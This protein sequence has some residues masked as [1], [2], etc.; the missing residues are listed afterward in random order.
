MSRWRLAYGP[1]LVL[2]AICCVSLNSQQNEPPANQPAPAG[3]GGTATIRVEARLVSLDVV[4]TDDKGD[5]VPGLNRNDFRVY[6]NGVEQKI[7]DFDSWQQ[8]PI[9]PKQPV[10]DQY[11][12]PDWG[13]TPLAI[14]VLDELSTTFEDSAYAAEML[15]RYLR[16]EPA[17]LPVP[18][19]LMMVSDSGY[20]VLKGLTRDRETLIAAVNARPPVV[21]ARLGRGDNDAILVQTFLILQQIAL[22][23][24]GLNQHKSIIWVGAGFSGVDPDS[25]DETT[26]DSLKKATHDTVNLLMNTHTTVYKIDPTPST[27]STQPTVDISDSLA[28]GF[29]TA[30]AIAQPEDPLKDNFNFNSFVVETGGHYFYGQND[31]DRYFR[32]AIDA[33]DKFY[34]ITFVP[35]LSDGNEPE[36]YRQIV[37]K[38]NRPGLH[39][40]TRQG[41]YSHTPPEPPPTSQ[42]LGFAV[43]GVATGDMAFTGVGVRV[44]NVTPAKLP[45]TA[46]VTYQVDDHS[47]T[48]SDGPNGIVIAD[49]AAVLVALDAKHN[50]LGSVAYRLHPY[51]SSADTGQRLT[52]ALTVR[53]DITLPAKTVELRLIVRDSSGR[54]GT[55]NV[56]QAQLA[57]ILDQGPAHGHSK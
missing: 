43:A 32:H 20:R 11:G 18:T 46:S 56:P 4:V 25:M 40:T 55:T 13:P 19:M 54:I 6:E 42:Q 2:S 48:W 24:A 27:T 26:E 7:R 28:L 35:P 47:L 3:S 10:I 29:G 30:D 8:R 37:I 45:R 52:G 17:E 14:L 9:V 53:D 36:A 22:A 31:L 44:L 38:V 39:I 41:Y 50:I 33:T 57:S 21:P 5:P 34:T 1:A 12:R 16:A 23:E 49:A 51:L 15:K